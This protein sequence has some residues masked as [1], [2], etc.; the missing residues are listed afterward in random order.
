MLTL[1]ATR[2]GP[3]RPSL[4]PGSVF[5]ADPLQVAN[6]PIEVSLNGQAAEVL[7]AGGDP[8]SADRFQVNFRVPN[9]LAPGMANLQVTAA[10]IAGPQVRIAIQ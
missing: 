8:G 9:G 6:S 1:Y 3:T 2:L 10:W 4:Q 7:Y 5:T